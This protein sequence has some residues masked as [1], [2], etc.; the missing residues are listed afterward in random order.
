MGAERAGQRLL[1]MQEIDAMAKA[2]ADSR[3]T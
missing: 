2:D 1:S 3:R